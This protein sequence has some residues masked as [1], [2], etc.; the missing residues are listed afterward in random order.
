[1]GLQYVLR[2]LLVKIRDNFNDVRVGSPIYMAPEALLKNI[3]SSKTDVWAF[4]LLLY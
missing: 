1:M 3:Y 2:N 4:G